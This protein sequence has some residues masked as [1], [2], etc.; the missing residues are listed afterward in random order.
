[1]AQKP[2]EDLEL[3]IDKFTFRFPTGL[4]FSEA[5]LWIRREGDLVRLGLSDFAQRRA[6]DV[7]FASLTPAGTVLGVGDEVA[8]VETVKVNVS[9]PS[10]VN[11]IVREVNSLLQ[12]T[13]E[14]INQDP[15]GNGWIAL[16]EAEDLEAQLNGLLDAEMCVALARRQAEA[17][18][19]PS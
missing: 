5:G 1:M 2:N 3:R 10:P 8:S 6:G 19:N 9:L 12:D 18:L 17:E 14:L 7:A 4:R 16:M 11:G 13:P 15:Y